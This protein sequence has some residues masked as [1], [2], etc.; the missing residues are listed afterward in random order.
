MGS[1]ATE[2]SAKLV[3]LKAPVF[4]A[5]TET[6]DGK[7]LVTLHSSESSLSAG[8]ASSMEK[9]L[10]AGGNSVTCHVKRHS[11]RALFGPKSLEALTS[12]FGH[13]EIVYDPTRI[14]GRMTSLVGLARSIRLSL[15]SKEQVMCFGFLAEGRIILWLMMSRS[16]HC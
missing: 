1:I 9:I 4:L 6:R 8:L 15:S 5:R 10:G 11:M 12:R 13:G 7:T 2:I 3:S 16:S 14:V